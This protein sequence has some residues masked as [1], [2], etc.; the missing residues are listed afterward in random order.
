MV[1]PGQLGEHLLDLVRDEEFAALY[2]STGR[3]ARSPALLALVTLFQFVEDLPDR[4][5]VEA[6]VVRLD[7]KY[8]LHLPL[9]AVGFHYSELCLFRGRLLAH[10][11]GR[12]VFDQ[13]TFIT[14]VSTGNASG[15]DTEELP[16]IR[17]QPAAVV[18]LP[19]EQVVDSGYIS[20]QQLAQSHAASKPAGSVA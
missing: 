10:G 19:A 13:P 15:G 6:L 7:W 2:P 16:S 18:Q 3:Q 11:A 8:A 14:D 5:A 1:R 20:G 17:A 12:L 9:D 4:A